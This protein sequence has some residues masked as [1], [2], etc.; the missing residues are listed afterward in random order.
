MI[1]YYYN[2]QWL[3]TLS[4]CFHTGRLAEVS[5]IEMT[6]SFPA[7]IT[8]LWFCGLSGTHTLTTSS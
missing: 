8:W 7:V 4:T 6:P 5:T 1:Y 2:K 3:L